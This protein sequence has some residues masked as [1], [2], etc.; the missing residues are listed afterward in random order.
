MISKEKITSI[1]LN[2]FNEKKGWTPYRLKKQIGVEQKTVT[3][4]MQ[5][6]DRSFM[7]KSSFDLVN[8]KL[9][10]DKVCKR[11]CKMSESEI[12]VWGQTPMWST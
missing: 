1:I 4:W 11:S 7:R 8:E 6:T 10:N 9:G 3:K 12:Y 5:E 2:Y